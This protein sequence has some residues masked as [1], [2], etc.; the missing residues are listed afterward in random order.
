MKEVVIYEVNCTGLFSKFYLDKLEALD[1]AQ[2]FY[3]RLSAERQRYTDLIIDGFEI[4]VPKDYEVTTANKLVEDLFFNRIIS[5]QYNNFDGSFK[6]S[7]IVFKM[8]F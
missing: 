6:K 8:S 2:A 3:E 1:Y 4:N 7:K 5:P